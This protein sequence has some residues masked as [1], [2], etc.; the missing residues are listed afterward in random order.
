MLTFADTEQL[1]AVEHGGG[2]RLVASQQGYA[3]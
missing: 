2:V 1:T 3:T